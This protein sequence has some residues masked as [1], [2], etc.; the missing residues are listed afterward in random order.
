M[1]ALGTDIKTW[2]YDQVIAAYLNSV[3][4]KL[5]A[6]GTNDSGAAYARYVW[7]AQEDSTKLLCINFEDPDGDGVYSI[8][9]TKIPAGTWVFKVAV[10]RSW[11][12]NYGAGGAT[13]GA[14]G[15]ATVAGVKTDASGLPVEYP[16]AF[17]I[18]Q[19][20]YARFRMK[21][22]GGKVQGVKV[23]HVEYF[24]PT[25]LPDWEQSEE[26]KEP[27]PGAEAATITVSISRPT[28]AGGEGA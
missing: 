23:V 14:G 8:A 21:Y 19:T 16:I 17:T 20:P 22:W 10:G 11:A 13:G 7:T 24:D 3:D 26:F 18:G 28:R 12:E 9:T 1:H 5:D 4:G 2:T 25:R 15:S 6:S 27:Y